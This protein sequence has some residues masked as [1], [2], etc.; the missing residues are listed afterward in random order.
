M[1]WNSMCPV[2]PSLLTVSCAGRRQR[3]G[4]RTH[5]IILQQASEV[6]QEV[7]VEIESY[8]PRNDSAGVRSSRTTFKDFC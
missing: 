7:A 8:L 5:D 2:Y 6:W 1:D 4:R 3:N